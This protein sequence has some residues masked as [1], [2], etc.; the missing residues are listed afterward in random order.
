MVIGCKIAT[1]PQW[2]KVHKPTQYNGVTYTRTMLWKMRSEGKVKLKQVEHYEHVCV[3][4][5]I[6]RDKGKHCTYVHT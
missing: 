6:M 5:T 1:R 3:R 2:C 4:E